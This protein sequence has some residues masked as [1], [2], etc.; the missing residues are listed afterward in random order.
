M[1]ES[2]FFI[3]IEGI[4][5]AGKDT[6]VSLLASS[7]NARILN[8]NIVTTR[9]PGGTK[10]GRDLMEMM[11]LQDDI[12]PQVELCLMTAD[13][14]IHVEQFIKPALESCQV[15][16]S[17]RYYHSTVAYQIYGNGLHNNG[18]FGCGGIYPDLTFILDLSYPT[19]IERLKKR[20]LAL[21]KFETRGREYYES[22][23]AGYRSFYNSDRSFYNSDAVR[24]DNLSENLFPVDATRPEGEIS[25]IITDICVGKIAEQLLQYPG[26]LRPVLRA[27]EEGS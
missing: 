20:G 1:R 18:E 19:M 16:I 3:V 23:I 14:L 6:Q 11:I 21:S 24:D 15:V 17:N 12:S 22:V 5:G 8:G 7:L 13:R 9:E 4:D 26:S 27:T 25:Q 2:G 10:L